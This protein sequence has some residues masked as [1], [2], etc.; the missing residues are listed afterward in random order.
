MK[1]TWTPDPTYL[2]TGTIRVQTYR[3][4][5][6][7]HL[8]HTESKSAGPDGAPCSSDTVGELGR[9]KV[10]I[11][12]LLHIGKE[13]HELEEVQAHLVA[14]ASTYITYVDEPEEWKK[15]L[16]TLSEISRRTLTKLSG[17]H[18]RSI[19]AIL[20]RSR[21]PHL[22]HRL[23][24]REIAREWRRTHGMSEDVR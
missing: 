9:L 13:S 2:E 17:L 1:L 19:R 14:P 15:D 18:P 12:D 6:R 7:R 5:V 22:G 4:V 8:A 16:Q 23:L 11:L 21:E 10:E 3:D 24:L 20:N